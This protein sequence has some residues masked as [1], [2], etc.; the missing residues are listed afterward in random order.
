[1]KRAGI[2]VVAVLL[3]LAFVIYRLSTLPPK[4]QAVNKPKVE[5]V[6]NDPVVVDEATIPYST[7]KVVEAK[8]RISSKKILLQGSQLQ[9][10]VN[11]EINSSFSLSYFMSKEVFKGVS[12]GDTVIVKYQSFKNNTVYSVE[13]VRRSE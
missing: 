4:K 3:I 9:Y 6:K 1:M 13:S 5:V 7:T 12:S 10:E 8:G 2:V 11:I